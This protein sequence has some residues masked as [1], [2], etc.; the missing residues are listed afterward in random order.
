MVGNDDNVRECMY[1]GAYR[2]L[3][4]SRTGLPLL[5]RI[6]NLHVYVRLLPISTQLFI[7]E[8]PKQGCP[9]KRN[10]FKQDK[11]AKAG[12]DCALRISMK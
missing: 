12:H 5:E 8:E 10:T 2:Q 3:L 9:N 7:T 6:D 11:E 1:H 4:L